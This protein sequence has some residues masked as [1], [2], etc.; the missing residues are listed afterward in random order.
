MAFNPSADW[1]STG[2]ASGGKQHCPK[3]A[4]C[5]ED[6]CAFGDE[7]AHKPCGRHWTDVDSAYDESVPA[8]DPK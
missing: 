2:R 4:G 5:S 3:C 8:G 6:Y 1:G 7:N